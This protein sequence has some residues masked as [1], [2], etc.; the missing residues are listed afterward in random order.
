M[1]DPPAAHE[2]TAIETLWRNVWV[3]GATYVLLVS[4]LVLFL[5]TQRS[6]YG[7]AL[8]VGLIGFVIAYVFNPVVEALGRV[9]IGRGFA[10]VIVYLVL[11]QA[12]VVGS[13]LLT[14][15]VTETARF[16]SLLPAALGNLSESLGTATGWFGGIGEWFTGLLQD[17]LGIE[18]GGADF[19][20]QVQAQVAA[21]LTAA[22]QSLSRFLERVLAEGPSVLLQ[23]ATS[24]VSGAFQGVLIAIASAYLLYDYPRVTANVRRFVPSRWRTL[25]GDLAAKA[26]RAIGGYLRGQIL[27]TVI[28]GFLIWLGL[29]ILGVPLATAIAVLSAVF[30]LVPYLGPIVGAT[31]AILLA[32]TVSPLTALLVVVVFVA[33]NQIEGHVLAPLI[34]AKSTDLHPV[35]V[36]ISILVGVGFLGLL[37]ALLAVPVVAM[38]KVVLEEYLLTRPSYT[39]EV[40]AATAGG[41]PP[42]GASAPYG[43]VATEA[44]G[45]APVEPP[46]SPGDRRP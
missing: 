4:A 17:R 33:A 20:V 46:A 12:L 10:V 23:G 9:R 7:F 27:I 25:Y 44:R 19:A 28:V 41:P 37:G 31:P 30:N 2:V 18:V 26:D 43:D 34:L 15:V 13:V 21:W 11:A 16:A 36:L 6:A 22:A 32:F 14:Q 40:A 38:A 39:G 42:G 24:I 3:R 5:V 8:Q 29:T 45:D 35:T 1:D